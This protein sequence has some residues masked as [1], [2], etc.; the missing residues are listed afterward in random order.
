MSGVLIRRG[1][2]SGLVT[3]A[4]AIVIAIPITVSVGVT[5]VVMAV[6][7]IVAIIIATAVTMMFVAFA[8]KCGKQHQSADERNNQFHIQILPEETSGF[9]QDKTMG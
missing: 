5:P 7:V 3:I 6:P 1:F 2:R 8:A 4:V 9:T